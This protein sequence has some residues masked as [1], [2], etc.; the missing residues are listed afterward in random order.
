M[1]KIGCL[2]LCLY[3]IINTSY[4]QEP[5]V[6]QIF[7][8]LT[9]SFNEDND[10]SNEDIQEIIDDLTYINHHPIA[11]NLASPEDLRQLHF[12]NELQIND[13]IDYRTKSGQIYSI[14]EMA[15]VEG[16]SFDLIE[17]LMPFIT[18]EIYE[19]K[20]TYKKSDNDLIIRST[21]AFSNFKDTKKSNYDG[22]MER[23][24][25]R[26]KHIS[27]NYE[28]GFVTEKDPG[29][30]LFKSSN[31][32][33][34]DYLSAYANFKLDRNCKI[35]IGDYSVQFGQ[36]LIASQGF[37]LGKSSETTDVFRYGQGIKSRSSTDEN[38]FFRGI[39]GK[40]K[41]GKITLMPF[42]S[43]R[44]LDAKIDTLNG[45]LSF[46]A[47]QTSGYHRTPSE[48][49]GKNSLRQ[50]VTGGAADINFNRWTIGFTGIFT[51]FN[52]EMIR[53][54]EPYNQFLWQGIE[55]FVAGL[56]WKGSINNIFFFGEMASSANNGKAL[57]SGV[58][59]KPAPNA[60]MTFVYR[61]IN[62]TYFSFFSNAFTESSN[63]NDEQGL[64]VGFTYYPA[65]RF[66]FRCYADAYKFKWIKYTTAAPSNG[67][68]L[69]VQ[70]AFKATDKTELYARFFQEEK[71]VKMIIANNKYNQLQTI[72]RYRLNFEHVLNQSFS[73]KSR[74]EWMSYSKMITEKG[75]YIYQDL[76]YKPVLGKLSFNGRIGYFLTDGYN[77]RIYSYENDLLYSFSIPSFF[78]EGIRTYINI[79]QV[80]NENL[81]VWFKVAGT[82]PT[83][84]PEQIS[85]DQNSKYELKVQLKYQF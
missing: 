43:F 78:G 22:S 72:N 77:S 20:S 44:Q 41:V 33:G 17:K 30:S 45:K 1:L 69:F 73:L 37:S 35:F 27:N 58:L 34:F 6:Q 61:N 85:D 75:F 60:E 47:F 65:A 59:F 57:L 70:I 15:S 55:T 10:E 50:F 14:Y 76:L 12:L 31:K 79:K 9:E 54:P 74:V 39:A 18:F 29:E 51:H 25:L 80:I 52:A 67:T 63:T 21:R 46:G 68:E 36:G 40:L 62:K 2:I 23:Y 64:Y 26:F 32:Y 81:S 53:S 42:V 5:A 28:Y 7:E 13:L 8:D 49:A 4:A 66:T 24:Y 19:A 82:F 11:I 3:I 38:H 83:D 16:Y 56:N 48:I 84:D 71:G